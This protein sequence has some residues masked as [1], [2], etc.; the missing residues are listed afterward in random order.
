MW[1]EGMSI[2]SSGF[3][4]ADGFL[5]Q[6]GGASSSVSKVCKIAKYLGILNSLL[7]GGRS[8]TCKNAKSACERVCIEQASDVLRQERDTVVRDRNAAID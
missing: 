8:D 7:N 4:A 3:A 6:V 1:K 5:S 2:L